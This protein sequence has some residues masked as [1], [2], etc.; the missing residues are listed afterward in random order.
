MRGPLEIP[1]NVV[2]QWRKD[3]VMVDI[4]GCNYWVPRDQVEVLTVTGNGEDL[5]V[6]DTQR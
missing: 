5:V 4:G 6:Q 1:G 3:R 2:R